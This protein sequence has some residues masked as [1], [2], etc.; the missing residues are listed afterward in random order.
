MTACLTFGGRNAYL[1]DNGACVG[2]GILLLE[3]DDYGRWRV[4]PQAE[5]ERLFAIGLG[6]PI[7]LSWR[8]VKLASVARSL[9]VGD[10]SLAA[11]TL[12]QAELPGLPENFSA[13]ISITE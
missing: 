13:D 9:N 5:L 12:E 2:A 7:D 1:D 11:L 8:M 3:R 6:T 4:R 10:R